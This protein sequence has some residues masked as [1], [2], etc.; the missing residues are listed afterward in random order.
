MA[1]VLWQQYEYYYYYYT[2]AYIGEFALELVTSA[3]VSEE[4]STIMK[5]SSVSVSVFLILAALGG[6]TTSSFCN[7][8]DYGAKGDGVSMQ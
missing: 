2:C 7:V 3:D 6:T 4:N 8:K 5:V 1:V